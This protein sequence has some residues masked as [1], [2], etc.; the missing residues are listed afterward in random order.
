MVSDLQYDMDISSKVESYFVPCFRRIDRIFIIDLRKYL[1]FMG[2]A[3]CKGYW[4]ENQTTP[5]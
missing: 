4:E 1:A 2:K 5:G 3:D